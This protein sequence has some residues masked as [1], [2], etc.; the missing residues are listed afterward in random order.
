MLQLFYLYRFD[1]VVNEYSF[2][3]KHEEWSGLSIKHGFC[4]GRT[5]F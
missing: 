3:C 1:E 4:A 2:K 5:F